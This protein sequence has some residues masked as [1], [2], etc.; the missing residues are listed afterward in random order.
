[1]KTQLLHVLFFTPMARGQWGL[2][3]VMVG[4]PGEAKTSVLRSFAAEWGVPFECLKV[5]ARG[6]GAFG[7]VPVPMTD[8]DDRMRLCYPPPAWTDKFAR[9]GVGLVLLDEGSTA[10]DLIQHALMGMLDDRVIG[11]WAFP[12]RVRFIMA[13]NPPA[14]V[15]GY[16]LNAP[17]ANRMGHFAW[18][19]P[20]DDQW[21]EYMTG[22]VGDAPV[23]AQD[24][25]AEEA[26]VLA[27]W[28]DQF[29]QAFG[30]VSAFRRSAAGHDL[31]RKCPPP[32]DPKAS[33]AFPTDRTWEYATRALASAR[34]HALTKLDTEELLGGFIGHEALV[35]L[36]TYAEYQDLPDA[37]KY[38][39][40]MVSFEHSAGR[41]DRT[42][43]M[44]QACTSIVRDP[45]CP[46]RDVRAAMVWKLLVEVGQ[47]Y[48]ETVVPFAVKLAK[49]GLNKGPQASEVMRLI[50]P[51]VVMTTKR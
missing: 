51:A 43:A 44:L 4:G 17:T 42:F 20:T 6:E 21:D 40:G 15:R 38:L 18:D 50:N 14:V 37:G 19:P 10:S 7:V 1:M 8:A 29:A 22:A 23:V 12:P 2:P 3:A 33:G 16:D 47:S 11:E 24:C 26:R 35:A 41:L 25:D 28:K 30:L 49:A 34:I 36:M 46:N 32:E 13:S 9:V 5:G 39:D 45:V 48:L 31:K 27:V